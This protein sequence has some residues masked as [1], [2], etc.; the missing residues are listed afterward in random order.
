MSYAFA[1]GTNGAIKGPCEPCVTS[2]AEMNDLKHH[3]RCPLITRELA[4]KPSSFSDRVF[5][6]SEIFNKWASPVSPAPEQLE[7]LRGF[8]SRVREI[9]IY[10]SQ[11]VARSVQTMIDTHANKFLN[12][13]VF[14]WFLDCFLFSEF[15]FSFIWDCILC[16]FHGLITSYCCSLNSCLFFYSFRACSIS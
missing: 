9:S 14:W 6:I 11:E 15:I 3:K 1:N 12:H 16:Q 7:H 4:P 2:Y 13:S 8:Y 5:F 10:S